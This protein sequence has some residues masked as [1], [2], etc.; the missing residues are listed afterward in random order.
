MASFPKLPCS[1]F[2][3]IPPFALLPK[4][5]QMNGGAKDAICKLQ[6]K[7]KITPK[8]WNDAQSFKAG[9]KKGENE[10]TQIRLLGGLMVYNIFMRLNKNV[11]IYNG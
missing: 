8:A 5:L 4:V 9:I 3:L 6:R 2:L 7:S 11:K 1:K 10:I